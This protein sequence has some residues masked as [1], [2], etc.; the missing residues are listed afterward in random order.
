MPPLANRFRAI[1]VLRGLTVALMIVVNMQIGPGKSYPP[2]LHAAWNGLTPTDLVFPTFMFVVGAALSFTLGKYAALGNAAVI[3][4][5]ATRIALIF[6]CG[7]LLYWFPFFEMDASGHFS[8]APL[9]ETRIMGVL[10][11]IA[12]GYGVAS[13][14]L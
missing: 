13:L 1:D 2:L 9:S 3:R 7:F 4:K 8:F 5:V 11:R 6:L 14:I 12:I 10:Q